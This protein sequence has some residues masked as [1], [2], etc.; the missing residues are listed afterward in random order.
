MAY[1]DVTVLNLSQDSLLGQLAV[2]IAIAGPRGNYK[3]EK[4]AH[5]EEVVLEAEKILWRH[6]GW[7]FG[8]QLA[9]NYKRN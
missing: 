1:F 4:D 8:L 9:K 3:V 6:Y 2:T 5:H 7:G